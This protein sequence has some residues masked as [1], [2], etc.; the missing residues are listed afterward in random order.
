[1]AKKMRQINISRLPTERKK[2]AWQWIQDNRPEQAALIE[3]DHF[4]QMIKAFDGEIIIE[5]E[6][7]QR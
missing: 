2:K 3:S 4:Q 1:M 6:T 7:R 5:M